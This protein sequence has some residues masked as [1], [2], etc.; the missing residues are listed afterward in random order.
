MDKSLLRAKYRQLRDELTPKEINRRSTLIIKNLMNSFDFSDK[1]VSLFLPIKSKGEVDTFPLLNLLY[2]EQAKIGLSVSNFETHE[3]KHL[4]YSPE[5]ILTENNYGIPEPESGTILPPLKFDSVLVPLLAVDIKGNRVG[6]GKG[7]YDRFLSAC[8]KD[9][10]FIGLHLF[11]PE[12]H[13]ISNDSNDIPLHNI[14]TPS[15][16]IN[17]AIET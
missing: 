1:T 16:V 4:C 10:V 15:Q 12:K 14:V 6:Y 9:C 7:F 11:E 13:P 8:R 2:K 3:M 17:C 5:T